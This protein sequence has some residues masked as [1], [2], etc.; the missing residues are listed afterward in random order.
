MGIRI[1]IPH[2]DFRANGIAVVTNSSITAQVV[3]IQ[4]S[5]SSNASNGSVYTATATFDDGSTKNVTS[6]ATWSISDNSCSIANGVVTAPD[7]I[8]QSGVIITASYGGKSATKTVTVTGSVTVGTYLKTTADGQYISLN[9]YVAEDGTTF[10]S[11]KIKVIFKINGVAATNEQVWAVGTRNYLQGAYFA[12]NSIG[13]PYVT[14]KS[15]NGMVQTVPLTTGSDITIIVDNTGS[16]YKTI[17]NGTE[18]EYNGQSL[19]TSTIQTIAAFSGFSAGGVDT[20]TSKA[21]LISI[22]SLQVWSTKSGSETLIFDG[23]PA[24]SESRPCLYDNVKKTA[25]YANTGELSLS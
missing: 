13:T 16:N 20:T 18:N 5:G 4:V 8:N 15:S 19:P 17:L 11:I 12:A 9:D 24:V 6:Q 3:S 22:K 1:T 14:A 23:I 10:G 25:H 2:S 21:G 7:I